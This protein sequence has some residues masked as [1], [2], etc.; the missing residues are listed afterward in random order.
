MWKPGRDGRF[1]ESLFFIV[2]SI[3]TGCLSESWTILTFSLWAWAEGTFW[4]CN[5]LCC[6]WNIVQLLHVVQVIYS[7]CPQWLPEPTGL[8]ASA[9][10]GSSFMTKHGL[11]LH[12][13]WRTPTLCLCWSVLLFVYFSPGGALQTS[14]ARHHEAA[15]LAWECREITFHHTQQDWAADEMHTEGAA[16]HATAETG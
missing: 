8:T 15:S 13:S 11:R 1:N 2:W 9:V 7:I 4:Q 3:R 10:A 14:R 12:V 16:A 6:L 5:K